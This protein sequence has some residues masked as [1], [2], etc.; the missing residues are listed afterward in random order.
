MP[1]LKSTEGHL[2]GIFRDKLVLDLVEYTGWN[3]SDCEVLIDFYDPRNPQYLD[4]VDAWQRLLCAGAVTSKKDLPRKLWSVGVVK[5]T[6]YQSFTILEANPWHVKALHQVVKLLYK[7]RGEPR[8]VVNWQEVIDRLSH[9]GT[10]KLDKFEVT[11]MRRK[12]KTL[13]P[14]FDWSELMGRFGPGVTAD[15]KSPFQRW[16]REFSRPARVPDSLYCCGIRDWTDTVLPTLRYG[17]TKMAE[18]PKSLKTNRFV[19]SEPAGFMFAQLAVGDAMVKALHKAFPNN[20][21]LFDQRRHNSLLMKDGYCSIDLSDASDHVSRRLVALLLPDWKDYLFA[22]RSTFGCAPD[23]TLFPFR[24]FAPMGSGV[25]FPV[26]TAVCTLLCSYI[27]RKPFHVYGDDIIVHVSD[28]DATVDILTR[29]GLVVNKAKSCS[30]TYYRESCG[31]E[32]YHVPG[33]PILDITPR[34]IRQSPEECSVQTIEDILGETQSCQQPLATTFTHYCDL[35]LAS[36]AIRGLSYNKRYQ[37]S[38]VVARTQIELSTPVAVPGYSGLNRWF[39]VKPQDQDHGVLKYPSRT[40]V[41]YRPIRSTV[42]PL[43]VAHWLSGTPAAGVASALANALGS[44]L[45]VRYTSA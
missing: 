38:T 10:I 9:P 37:Y 18:V 21:S 8:K 19:S 32:I 34:Y 13:R 3:S 5:T 29:A 33:Q 6:P 45:T 28:F 1:N 25:C 24:A 36:G 12:A 7:Y 4:R 42:I 11:A 2:F 23:G 15:K 27:C 31:V 44:R 16:N 22:V 40:R 17:I 30:T 41:V 43:T 14:P 20:V 35:A 26:L 39:L